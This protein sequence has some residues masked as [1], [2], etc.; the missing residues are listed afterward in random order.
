[1]SVAHLPIRLGRSGTNGLPVLLEFSILLYQTA[2]LCLTRENCSSYQVC[3]FHFCSESDF[4]VGLRFDVCQVLGEKVGMSGKKWGYRAKVTS[5]ENALCVG[6]KPKLV[7]ENTMSRV[8]A[9]GK[10]RSESTLTQLMT[11]AGW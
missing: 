7:N 4:K 6:L 2:V 10:C 3:V 8:G 9:S 5:N 11:K 1:L